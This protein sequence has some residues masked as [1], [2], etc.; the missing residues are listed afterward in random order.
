MWNGKPGAVVSNSPGNLS[1]FGVIPIHQFLEKAE[2]VNYKGD[3][4]IELFSDGVPGSLWQQNPQE[5]VARCKAG[6]QAAV[7][8]M[9]FSY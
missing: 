7:N 1:A 8:K 2:R 4:V 5:V 3:F 6:M 9:N